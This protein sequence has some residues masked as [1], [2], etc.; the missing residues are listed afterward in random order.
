MKLLLSYKENSEDDKG[1][2]EF[3]MTLPKHRTKTH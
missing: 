2:N 3:E 1:F